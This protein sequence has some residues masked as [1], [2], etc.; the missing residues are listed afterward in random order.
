[1]CTANSASL[2]DRCDRIRTRDLQFLEATLN[3]AVSGRFSPDPPLYPPVAHA[4]VGGV[5]PD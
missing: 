2:S 4:P 1:V 5:N 3:V